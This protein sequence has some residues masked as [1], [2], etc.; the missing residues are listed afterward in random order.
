M[1]NQATTT[2]QIEHQP[3]EARLQEL[4]V[5]RWPIWSKEV[6]VFPWTALPTSWYKMYNQIQYLRW[7]V[8]TRIKTY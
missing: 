6:S 7:W 3:S 4:G 5:K 1:S 2:I 8:T